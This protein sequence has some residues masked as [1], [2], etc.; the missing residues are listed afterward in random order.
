MSLNGT[1]LQVFHITR[2]GDQKIFFSLLGKTIFGGLPAFL[3]GFLRDVI[4]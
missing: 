1:M 4:E 2:F 3:T